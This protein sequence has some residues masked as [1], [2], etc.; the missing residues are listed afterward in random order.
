MKTTLPKVIRIEPSSVCN[1]YCRHCPTGIIRHNNINYNADIMSLEFFDL[2]VAQIAEHLKTIKVIVLYHGGEPLIN[3]K[4]P[5]M[6]QRLKEIGVEFIKTVS[7]G[8]LLN[9]EVCFELIIA[10]LDE[11]EISIDG[12]TENE[13]NFI[14][15]GSDTKKIITAIK[16]L[17]SIKNMYKSVTP[18]ISLSSTQFVENSFPSF[19]YETLEKEIQTGQIKEIKTVRAMKWFDMGMASDE[20][21][22]FE[23]TGTQGAK[24]ERFC[25][26]LE[27]TMTIRSAGEV[28]ACCYDLTSKIIFGDAKKEKL[29]DIWYGEKRKEILDSVRNGTPGKYCLKCNAINPG[30]FLKLKS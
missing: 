26:S 4:M 18:N 20:S 15:R 5:F 8:M 11:I 30:Y 27:N 21:P 28:V 25:D 12:R 7:N 3:K 1:L 29:I 23:Y 22:D 9:D 24:I 16:R 17:I 2:L 10:G 13:N 6:V 19:L 14:R